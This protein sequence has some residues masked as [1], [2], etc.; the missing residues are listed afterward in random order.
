M[1]RVSSIRYDYDE[2]KIEPHCPLWQ[3]L[4]GPGYLN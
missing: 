2:G 4:T 1:S 3:L